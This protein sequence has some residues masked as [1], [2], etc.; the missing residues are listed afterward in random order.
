[1]ILK[2]MPQDI[3]EYRE[4]FCGS[5][6][7]FWQMPTNISRWINDIDSRLMEVYLSLRDKGDAFIQSCRQIRPEDD[8]DE[9]ILG[10]RGKKQYNKRLLEQ[11]EF[12]KHNATCDQALRYFFINR[13]CWGGKVNYNPKFDK[14]L[15]CSNPEGWNIVKTDKLER[16]AK[17][18][19]GAEITSMDFQL[20]LTLSGEDCWIFIDPPYFANDDMVEGDRLYEHLFTLEDHKRLI[21]L[22]KICKHRFCLCYDDDPRALELLDGTNFHINRHEWPYK[23]TS[24]K[25]KPMGQ[26]LIITNY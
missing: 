26:E 6:G 11:F 25:S 8:T 14:K 13:T 23:I 15:V 21:S 12:F 20:P 2:Y 4:P 17:I 7:I 24:L 5:A 3:K 19:N 16:A 1:M 9:T 22:L 18:L 10:K